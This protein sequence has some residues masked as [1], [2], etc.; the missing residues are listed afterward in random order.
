M[1]AGHSPVLI[2]PAIEF[3]LPAI[4]EIEHLSFEHA[5]ERFE[6]RKIRSL[7][8]SRRA[9]AFVADESGAI[10][11]WASGFTW[12]GSGSA[13]GRIY[14]LAIHPHYRGRRLGPKL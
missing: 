13:W 8:H 3:D 14:A 5:G 10:A 9:I 1:S 4:L 2:R 6:Q 12:S 11:G 7:I